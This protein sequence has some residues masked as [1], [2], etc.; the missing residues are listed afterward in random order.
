MLQEGGHISN[1]DLVER[2][3]LSPSACLR[4]MRVLKGG[5]ATTGYRAQLGRATLGLGLE[6]IVQVSM[7]QDVTD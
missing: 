5:G 2:A 1:Q 6:V 3:A 4:R 7:Y